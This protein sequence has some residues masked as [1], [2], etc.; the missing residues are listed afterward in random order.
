VHQQIE[1]EVEGRKD[2]AC[3]TNRRPTAVD[4][5]ANIKKSQEETRLSI[6]ASKLKGRSGERLVETEEVVLWDKSVK[7]TRVSTIAIID[8]R[9]QISNHADFKCSSRDWRSQDV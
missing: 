8:K 3:A 6:C 4:C 5:I 1:V 2:R 7:I 9:Q